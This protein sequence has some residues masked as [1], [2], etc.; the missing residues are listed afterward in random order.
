MIVS[1]LNYVIKVRRFKIISLRLETEI[2]ICVVCTITNKYPGVKCGGTLL[3]RIYE[4]SVRISKQF[5]SRFKTPRA[6]SY[7]LSYRT[8][9]GKN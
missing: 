1:R 9:G 3:K 2:V 7:C 6:G 5:V 4:K 8:D